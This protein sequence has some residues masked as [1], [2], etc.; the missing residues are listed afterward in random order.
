MLFRKLRIESSPGQIGPVERWYLILQ[1]PEDVLKYNEIET[2]L[3]TN[4]LISLPASIT[5]SHLEGSRESV[6]NTMLQTRAMN[7]KEG[8]KLYPI[9]ELAKLINGKAETM[10]KLLSMGKT[11]LV[12]QSAGYC[13]YESFADIWKVTIVDEVE[14][15]TCYFP[16][17][18]EPIETDLLYIENGERVPVDFEREIDKIVA[19]NWHNDRSWKSFRDTHD[20]QKY[21]YPLTE[22]EIKNKKIRYKL[23]HLKLR[24]P[25]FVSSMIEKAKVIAVET[26]LV[27]SIQID[28]MMKLFALLK[29]KTLYIKTPHKEDLTNH[30]LWSEC[31]SRHTV[32][33][34]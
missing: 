2:E 19:N 5:R 21:N 26:Q 27:D 15:D 7:L 28:R 13:D 22:D 24:D 17:D 4:A 11:V 33:F 14:K 16:T 3:M 1:T 32:N 6:I 8:E 30:E 12:Q 31:N 25:K 20:T 18:K 29:G 23:T 34:I 10:L 9:I